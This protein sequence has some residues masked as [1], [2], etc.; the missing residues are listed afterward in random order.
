VWYHRRRVR[1]SRVYFHDVKLVYAKHRLAIGATQNLT[2][3]NNRRKQRPNVSSAVRPEFF[4]LDEVT[5]FIYT[6]FVV[7]SRSPTVH[8]R[9]SWSL[10]TTDRFR[11]TGR[12]RP[13]RVP[14]VPAITSR[15]TVR[16][17]GISV[18]VIICRTPIVHRSVVGGMFRISFRGVRDGISRNGRVHSPECFSNR[19]TDGVVIVVSSVH[20]GRRYIV[21]ATSEKL[22][23]TYRIDSNWF[24]TYRVKPVHA[25]GL[26]IYI[27][28]SAAR[29]PLYRRRISSWR[30]LYADDNLGRR[31]NNNDNNSNQI[32]RYRAS[33][34]DKRSSSF[35]VLY[36]PTQT[37]RRVHLRYLRVRYCT[38]AAYNV[39]M[40]RLRGQ[41]IAPACS[42]R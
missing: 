13:F 21:H 4:V 9:S 6:S 7:A 8:V 32:Y 31:D 5:V 12:L 20:S 36:L 14:K 42:C 27:Y 15:Q 25:P 16:L 40:N 10:S 22:P 29:L 38:P 28:I 37:L 3:Q 2:T 23:T 39:K 17:P 18:R 35:P 33:C 11:R 34:C 1:A 26:N 24:K 19:P 41:G 30:V